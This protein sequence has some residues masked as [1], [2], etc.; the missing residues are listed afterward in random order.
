MVW[1]GINHMHFVISCNS[2]LSAL[3]GISSAIMLI[4]A[5]HTFSH[6]AQLCWLCVQWIC[7]A[8]S[9]MPSA[10]ILGFVSST[11]SQHAWLHRFAFS[12]HAWLFQL[13]LQSVCS[14]LLI[15]SFA[16]VPGFLSYAF[17]PFGWHCW[18][19]VQSVCLASSVMPL[20]N[21]FGLVSILSM[22]MFGL[23][24]AQFCC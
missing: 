20:T 7:L 4:I 1:T 14:P 8:L 19:C 13:C 2:V 6:C 11:I 9:A 10:S 23:V 3:L 16:S 24:G 18:L 5:S 15:M 17:R 21:N 12:E 22:S